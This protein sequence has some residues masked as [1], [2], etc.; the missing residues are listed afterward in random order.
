MKS[1][2]SLVVLSMALIVSFVKGY[3]VYNKG[4]RAAHAE[5]YDRDQGW[6]SDEF[7]KKVN[8]DGKE[9]CNPGP[10]TGCIRGTDEDAMLWIDCDTD[11]RSEKGFGQ[12]IIACADCDVTINDNGMIV[13]SEVAGGKT[14]SI[15]SCKGTDAALSN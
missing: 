12:A 8:V 11:S 4:C 14:R 9:C 10:D 1:T 13:V 2:L 5:L 7:S 15:Y 6:F 3:C